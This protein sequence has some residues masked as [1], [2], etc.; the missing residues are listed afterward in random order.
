MRD[1]MN[2]LDLSLKL[3]FSCSFIRKI[4]TFTFQLTLTTSYLFPQLSAESNVLDHDNHH[5]KLLSKCNATAILLLLF[6]QFVITSVNNKKNFTF[7][8]LK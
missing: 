7:N 6:H 1:I 8:R 3:L 4:N 2:V 5:E